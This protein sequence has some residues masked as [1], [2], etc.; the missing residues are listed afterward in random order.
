[1]FFFFVLHTHGHAGNSLLLHIFFAAPQ[2]FVERCLKIDQQFFH[3]HRT[4]QSLMINIEP[5][6]HGKRRMPP[7]DV[8]VHAPQNYVD[9]SHQLPL[10]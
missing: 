10:K 9:G 1:M 2:Q 4:I 8:T 7:C 5:D 3:C 6:T